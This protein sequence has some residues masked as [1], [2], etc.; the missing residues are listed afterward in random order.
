MPAILFGG[1]MQSLKLSLCLLFAGMIGLASANASVAAAVLLDE[2][3]VPRCK[4]EGEHGDYLSADR[5]AEFVENDPAAAAALDEINALRECGDQD[6]AY[7]GIVLAPEEIEAAAVT[8]FARGV[9][10]TTIGVFIALT[11]CNI[12]TKRA[13]ESAPWFTGGVVASG[14]YGAFFAV[15]FNSLLPAAKVAKKGVVAL[16]AP[17]VLAYYF[18]GT[19]S[20][21]LCYFINK[22]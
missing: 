22:R 6:V 8:P 10:M 20:Y 14:T 1:S 11:E 16:S 12:G 15:A 5:F 3:G 21:S 17:L 13:K 18:A 2:Q 4:I 7:A 19:G 9:I